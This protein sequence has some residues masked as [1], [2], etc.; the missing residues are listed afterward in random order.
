MLIHG[1]WVGPS[2][3]DP[4]RA[5]LA[6]RDFTCTAPAWRYGDRPVPGLRSDPDPRLAGV[7]VRELTDHYAAHLDAAGPQPLLVGHSFGGLI[8]QLLLA[9]GYGRAGVAINSAPTRGIVASPSALWANRAVALTWRSWRKV[10]TIGERGFAWAFL[11]N[12]EPDAR[13]EVYEAQVVPTPGRP[14]WQALLGSRATAVDYRGDRPPLLL[15]AGG[16]DRTV[17]ER[18]NRANLRRYSRSQAVTEFVSLPGRSHW[19]IAE[20][21]YEELVDLIADFDAR[22]PDGDVRN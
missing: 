17:T 21:G 5:E 19:T 10:L 1:A 8:V 11:H 9:R 6:A 3:W 15:I 16:A 20:P 18:M 13:R 12:L 7:G 2:C 22:H 14:F 4:I